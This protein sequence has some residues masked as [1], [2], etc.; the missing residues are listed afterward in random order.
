MIC[1]GKCYE[2]KQ[3]KRIAEWFRDATLDEG[4]VGDMQES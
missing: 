1:S 3:G 4:R 2:G